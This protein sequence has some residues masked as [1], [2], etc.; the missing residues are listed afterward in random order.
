MPEVQDTGYEGD[1]TITNGACSC[2]L[3]NSIKRECSLLFTGTDSLGTRMVPSV[4][5][6]YGWRH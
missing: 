5:M 1:C 2:G 4:T 3:V 6:W